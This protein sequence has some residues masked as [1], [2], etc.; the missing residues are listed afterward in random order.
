MYLTTALVLVLGASLNGTD[1]VSD[2]QVYGSY[3]QA[4]HTAA[5]VKRPMLV[6]LNPSAQEVAANNSISIEELRKDA[7]IS[8]LLE[9]YVVA[10][11]DT[12]TEHGKKVHELFGSQALPRVVVIDSKQK[13]QIY[14]TSE[15]LGQD[16]LKDVL[17]K[18]QDGQQ[19]Q[20]SATLNWAQQYVNPGNCPNCRRF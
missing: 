18:Y 8:E 19:I 14:R 5:D 7:E 6:I 1:A 20:A 17:E 13:Q 12:G 11:I 4:Y 10:E 9:N 2:A 15:H 16:Q 3:T